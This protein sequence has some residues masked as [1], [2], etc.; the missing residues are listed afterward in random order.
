MEARMVRSASVR[1][2]AL[3]D[4]VGRDGQ[5]DGHQ[6]RVLVNEVAALQVIPCGRGARVRTV[7]C[8]HAFVILIR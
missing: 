3:T 1:C 7:R 5:G 6:P 4:V 8:T 2:T